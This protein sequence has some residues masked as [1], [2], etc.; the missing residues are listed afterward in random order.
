MQKIKTRHKFSSILDITAQSDI[1]KEGV[2]EI[3]FEI[4]KRKRMKW[5]LVHE[6]VIHE[7]RSSNAQVQHIDLLQNSIVECVQEP[8]CV[9][10]L[11]MSTIIINVYI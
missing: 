5:Y 2:F 1:L 10:H 11:Q 3:F 9:G 6:G 7:V 4:V 8:G